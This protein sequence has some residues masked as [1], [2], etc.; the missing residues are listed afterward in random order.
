[1]HHFLFFI[2]I[3]III[4]PTHTV[5]DHPSSTIHQPPSIIPQ[6]TH[7]HQHN[8]QACTTPQAQQPMMRFTATLAGIIALASAAPAATTGKN[9]TLAPPIV[10]PRVNTQD[11]NWY[12][13]FFRCSTL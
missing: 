1:L 8:Y 12:V 4:T 9:S 10:I 5:P 2:V 13:F 7:P 3:I 11:S 6:F